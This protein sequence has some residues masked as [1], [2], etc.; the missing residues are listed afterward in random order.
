MTDINREIRTRVDAFVGEI[1]ELVR[2]AALDTLSG[3]LG[4]NGNSSRPTVSSLQRRN[5]AALYATNLQRGGK[6]TAREIEA[7]TDEIYK[8]IQQNPG[9]GVEQIS[10]GL[11][12][13]SKD[14][15]LPIKKLIATGK[16]STKGQKRAT[17][18]FASGSDGRRSRGRKPGR[19]R[20]N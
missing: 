1:S 20:K 4:A 10:M 18:Y 19:A 15:T 9:L 14:L 17:K 11:G 3:A 8:Y 6:R 16:L 2:L 12:Q 5:Q 13:P 7:M